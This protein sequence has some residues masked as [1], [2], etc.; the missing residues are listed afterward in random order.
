M[1]WQNSTQTDEG[2]PTRFWEKINLIAEISSLCR[3]PRPDG[4]SFVDVLQLI[5]TM[6]P[7]DAATIYVRRD[8]GRGLKVLACLAETVPLPSFLAEASDQPLKHWA[9]RDTKALLYT[10]EES[11]RDFGPDCPFDT[12]MVVPL[13][14]GEEAIGVLASGAFA[15]GMIRKKH[16]KLM[17]VIADQ[18]AVSLERLNYMAQIEAKNKALEQAH[19]RLKAAQKRI[20]AHEKLSAVVELAASINHEINNPLSVIVG[21]VQYLL[22]KMDGIDK[23]TADRL[24]RIERSAMRISEINRSLLGIESI[25]A[26][27]SPGD[28]EVCQYESVP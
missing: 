21:H 3:R 11:Q 9:S 6:V 4:S 1:I 15:V 18:V 27:D 8:D 23:E 5:Q 14:V 12:L 22:M 10:G 26:E 16:I 19:A 2:P 13:L 25:V 7:F 28:R 24:R 17:H 20:I